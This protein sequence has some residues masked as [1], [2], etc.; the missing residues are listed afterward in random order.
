MTSDSALPEAELDQNTITRNPLLLNSILARLI[1][2]LFVILAIFFTILDYSIN[3][4]FVHNLKDAKDAQLSLYKAVMLMDARIR[5]EQIEYDNPL[6]NP[7]F[8]ALDSGLYALVVNQDKQ[9]LWRSESSEDIQF[10]DSEIEPKQWKIG[11]QSFSE[12]ERFFIRQHTVLWEVQDDKPELLNFIVLEDKRDIYDQAGAYEKRLRI[13]YLALALSITIAILLALR[14]GIRPLNAMAG[15]LR[16]IELGKA[17]QLN[18]EY[19]RELKPIAKN[20]NQLL[21]AERQQK[22][23]FQK[24]LANLA[25][26]LKTPLAVIQSE[27]ENTELPEQ[28]KLALEEQLQRV[29]EIMEYQLK[30]AVITSPGSLSISVNV[31]DTIHSL[32]T[33]L[34]KVYKQKGVRFRQDIAA[35]VQFKCDDND[36]LELAGNLLDNACKHCINTVKITAFTNDE[37]QVLEVHDDGNGIPYSD[38]ETILKRGQRLDT[39]H[40]GHGLG[41]DTVVDIVDGYHGEL[42]IDASTLGG[43][44]FRVVLPLNY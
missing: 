12:N 38:R 4:L 11:G 6:P 31:A 9:F 30:R 15:S 8:E 21:T 17:Q 41:L 23:R 42:K 33:A 32:V 44:V 10:R 2:P 3:Q 40:H 16:A 24:T 35:D 29:T 20:L 13:A 7:R 25:H 28:R 5:D 43:A 37:V 22:Q 26:S 34:E 14:F 39:I 18:D 1:L 27:L 19:P 36:L